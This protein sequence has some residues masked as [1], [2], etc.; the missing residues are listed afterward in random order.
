MWKN[1]RQK[2]HKAQNIKKN[3]HTIIQEIFHDYW[4]FNFSKPLSGFHS[5]GE[6]SFSNIPNSIKS[7]IPLNFWLLTSSFNS[8]DWRFIF[9]WQLY[10]ERGS[11]DL[12]LVQVILPKV[13]QCFIVSY[14]VLLTLNA[15]TCWNCLL[16]MLFDLCDIRYIVVVVQLACD[17]RDPRLWFLCLNCVRAFISIRKRKEW[18]VKRTLF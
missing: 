3:S 5:K 17:T 12:W 1:P 11:T 13:N 7:C 4:N 16:L 15:S 6:N 9:A 18:D 10:L 2:G 14:A 8:L